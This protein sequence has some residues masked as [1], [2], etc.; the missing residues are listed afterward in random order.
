MAARDLLVSVHLLAAMVWTGGLVAVAVATT[1][2]RH[3]LGPA[4]QVRFF[5]ALGRRYGVTAG[6][7]LLIFA[8]TGLV[9]AGAPAGWTATQAAVAALTALI[10]ALTAIGV[11]NARA[12]QRL[13]GRALADPADARLASRLRSAARAATAVR[14]TIAVVTLVAVLTE[15]TLT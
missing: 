4:E 7:A 3:V 14:A 13:R 2:A 8:L 15:S 5:G 6:L 1:A 11:A 9:L 10:A 12:V